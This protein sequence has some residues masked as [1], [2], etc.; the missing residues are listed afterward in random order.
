M[1][2]PKT[3][4]KFASNKIFVEKNSYLQTVLTY[5][6]LLSMKERQSIA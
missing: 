2:L 3:F 4:K 5:S 6:S 1:V